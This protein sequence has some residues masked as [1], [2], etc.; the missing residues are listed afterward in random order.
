METIKPQNSLR[1]NQKKEK[2]HM[3]LLKKL[4]TLVLKI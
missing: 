3:K 2:L 1:V 4:K